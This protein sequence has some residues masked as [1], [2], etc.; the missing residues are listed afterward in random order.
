MGLFDVG[1]SLIADENMLIE[2]Y[3]P[4]EMMHRDGQKQEIANAL[5]PATVGRSI[6]NVF[7]YGETGVGKT[8]LTRWIFRELEKHASARVKTIYINC[9][10][11]STSHAILTEIL[12][13]LGVFTNLKQ[14]TN[15]L[16]DSLEKYCKKNSV[17]LVVALDEVDQLNDEEI[18]YTFS[19]G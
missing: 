1:N 16:I 3:V 2:E 17:S 19:R 12:L 14:P 9:W 11:R 8:S 13:K 4:E 18:L 7:L 10:K 6:S 15:E 5:K